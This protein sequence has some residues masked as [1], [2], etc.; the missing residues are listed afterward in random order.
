V[1]R[2]RAAGSAGLQ[3]VLTSVARSAASCCAISARCA[4]AARSRANAT[5]SVAQ[6]SHSHSAMLRAA[7]C[8][9]LAGL[10]VPQGYLGAHPPLPLPAAAHSARTPCAP[11]RPCSGSL[12]IRLRRCAVNR[13]DQRAV[14]PFL[15]CDRTWPSDARRTRFVGRRC[16][17]VRALLVR[18]AGC[19]KRHVR[20]ASH[21]A[22]TVR[23]AEGRVALTRVSWF[24]GGPQRTGY[25]G[26]EYG[27]T[28]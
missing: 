23:P 4:A 26:C 27:C 12:L 19:L 13:T 8:I 16:P 28:G 24:L 9:L 20:A 14:Q 11:P 17:M 21:E 7:R 25:R 5:H 1:R 15:N 10:Q 2:A 18:K 6:S 22:I 3:A